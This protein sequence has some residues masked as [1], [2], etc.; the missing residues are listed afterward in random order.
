[1][2]TDERE[3]TC[4]QRHESV[5]PGLRSPQV[6]VPALGNTGDS[7]YQTIII[8]ETIEKQVNN[9]HTHVQNSIIKNMNI[10]IQ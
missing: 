5:L 3:S 7:T 6:R 4:D 10:Y 9:T 2:M 8:S 1:M